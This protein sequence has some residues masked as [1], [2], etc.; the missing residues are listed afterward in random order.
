MPKHI[1]ELL[2]TLGVP[3]E[4]AAKI[5]SLPEAEQATF[6]AKPYVE[7]VK[8]NYQ[9][10]FQN[11]PAFFTDLTI[12]KLPP[13][14]KKQLESAAFG[15][16]ANIV[17]PKFLKI[18]GMTEADYA[19]VPEEQREKFE[20]LIPA[21]AER[22]VKTRG[23]KDG[24]KKLQ[25]ELIEARKQLEKYGPDY[26]KGIETK[27]QTA[28]DQKIAAA[29]FNSA[30]VG[31]LAAIPGLKIAA[32]DIAAT[33]SAQLLSK[34]GFE[35]IGDYSVELRQKA[36]PQMKVLKNGSSQELTLKDALLEIATER[37][38]VEKEQSDPKN[39]QG[40]FKVEPNGKGKLEMIP[41]HLQDKISKKI[42]AES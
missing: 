27:H 23:G 31:E 38:W 18:L 11:D 7:K 12:E 36:N 19:D 28:A 34:Y 16:A 2:T 5:D 40:K 9:T 6:D 32:S 14:V 1:V 21:I 8:G 15:R 22:W 10:Q 35:R 39:G 13:S 37:G 33:A 41:P 29:I 25:E 24:D 4:D 42:A 30:L 26:E 20:T 3:A 17:T